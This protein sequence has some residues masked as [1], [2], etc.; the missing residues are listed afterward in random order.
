MVVKKKKKR[1]FDD[2]PEVKAIFHSKCKKTSIL[3]KQNRKII[4]ETWREFIFQKSH[5]NTNSLSGR[6]IVSI[7]NYLSQKNLK[8]D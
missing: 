7:S 2:Y 4:A 1:D 8:L 5:L 6:N 3:E